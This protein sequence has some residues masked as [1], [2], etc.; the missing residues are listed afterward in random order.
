MRYNF[1]EYTIIFFSLINIF[2]TFQTL[3]NK[4]LRDLI[5]Y[6]YIIYLNDILIYFK[7]QEKY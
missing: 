4:T 7:T 5:N 2:V 1:F 6:I 3:I